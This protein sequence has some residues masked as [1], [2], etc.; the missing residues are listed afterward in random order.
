VPNA[1]L[2]GVSVCQETV[3]FTTIDIL[4]H[5]EAEEGSA[6]TSSHKRTFAGQVFLALSKA[7]ASQVFDLQRDALLAAGVRERHLYSD[8]ASAKKDDRSGLAA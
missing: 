6:A 1:R 8:T 3:P 4:A 5:A 7:D 2:A